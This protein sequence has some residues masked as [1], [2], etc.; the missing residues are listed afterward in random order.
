MVYIKNV[1]RFT[2]GKLA[3]LAG[4]NIQKVRYKGYKSAEV[5]RRNKEEEIG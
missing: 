4:V 1:D 2:I 3:R 5:S